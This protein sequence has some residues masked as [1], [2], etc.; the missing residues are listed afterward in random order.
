MKVYTTDQLRNVALVGHQGAGKTS[1]V[2]ALLFNAGA[3][4]RMG[5]VEEK[6][7]IS[8]YEE[9]EKERGISLGTTLIPC[10]FNGFKINVLDT[11]GYTDFQGE[12][13]GAISVADAVAVVVDAVA[14]VEVGTELAWAFAQEFGRPLIAV[15]NKMDRENANYQ[16]AIES[17]RTSFPDYKFV[18]VTLPI[19]QEHDFKG[20]V[21]VLTQKAYLDAGKS[22]S[23]DIPADMA[24]AV[25]EARLALIE[26]AAESDDQLMEKYFE[27][28]TLSTE[29][30][31]EGIRK[32]ARDPELKT[33]PVF[34]VSAT[35]NTAI[36]PLLEAFVAYVPT[37]D[38][39]AFKV[40]DGD[41][42]KVQEGPQSDDGQLAAYV[43]KTT[44]DKF[45]GTL[46]YFRIFSGSMESDS[47]FFNSSKDV[48]E[49][50]GSLLVMRGKDQLP[51]DEVHAGDIA[52]AAKLAQT[53]TGDTLTVKGGV[54]VV[55]PEFPRPLYSVA[56]TPRTQADS[57]K[58]GTILTSI[59]DTDPTLTW[60]QESA[61]K[62]TILEGMGETHINVAIKRAEQLGV[63]LDTAMP[64]VPYLETISRSASDVYRHKKQTGGAGQFAEVHLRV[65]PKPRGEGFEFASEV[66]GGAVSQPFISS[67]EKGVRQALDSGPI[68]G[69][70]VVD[71]KAVIFD[72]KEHPVDSK[73]IAFQIAG[74]G[75]FRAAMQNAGPTLLE[76]IMNVRVIV[77][78][79]NMGDIMG[80]MNTRRGRVQGMETEGG[81]SVVTAQVPLA[82]MQRYGNDLRSMTGGRGIYEMEFDRYD[83]VPTHLQQEII[84]A[85]KREEEEE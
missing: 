15:V 17:L 63:G 22:P 76:P 47:R 26:A 56:L 24:D 53:G 10:E 72:G 12:V 83:P 62:Q 21:N 33:V 18:P 81:K 19:G 31:R 85:A 65:D 61:T 40:V 51:V 73:D 20:V 52:A 4:N 13:K 41:A 49:R 5:R 6:N 75:S 34:A 16:A 35:H 54:Q 11:P 44:T 69:Y 55:V 42:V 1:L 80:D 29:E 67:T 70:P 25:E 64:K 57:A 45:V 50:V 60:R 3:I 74:R 14:G 66:V 68:A 43:F 39:R 23:G 77:P 36:V 59:C 58:M 79:E 27:E 48:E 2:E 30:V 46:N 28:E 7:T 32:A 8:D 71:I 37:P 78:E 84:D 38:L 82:E 9:E